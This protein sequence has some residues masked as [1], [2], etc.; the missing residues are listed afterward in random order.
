MSNYF[1]TPNIEPIALI[2]LNRSIA[3][4]GTGPRHVPLVIILDLDIHFL[5]THVS[6]LFNQLNCCFQQKSVEFF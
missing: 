1:A 3:P 5:P 4:A 2:T 6:L